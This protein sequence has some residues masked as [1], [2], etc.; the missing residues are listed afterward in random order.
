MS[1]APSTESAAP[2]GKK[3]R[4][5]VL[6]HAN[7]ET[8]YRLQSEGYKWESL[9]IYDGVLVKLSDGKDAALAQ[10]VWRKGKKMSCVPLLGVWDCEGGYDQE[11]ISKILDT[12]VPVI[13]ALQK[14]GMTD[15]QLKVITEQV[16]EGTTVVAVPPPK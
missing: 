2:G 1:T 16:P 6:P 11:Y 3:M 4:F 12:L 15:A 10:Q 5:S 7:L 14:M 13:S 8:S 9:R